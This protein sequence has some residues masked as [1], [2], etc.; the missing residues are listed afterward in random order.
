MFDNFDEVVLKNINEKKTFLEIL[1][2]NKESI[3]V[4]SK[5]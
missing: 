5:Q 4:F 3:T 2:Q 1:T